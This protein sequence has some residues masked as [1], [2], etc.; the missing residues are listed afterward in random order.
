VAELPE[1]VTAL[2]LAGRGKLMKVFISWSGVRSKAVAQTLYTWLKDV[3]PSVDPWASWEDIS[4]GKQWT[5]ELARQ[6]EAI[7][8]GVVCLTPENLP[9]PWLLF[10]A[11][12]ISKL[13]MEKDAHLCT[14]LIE[15]S[16]ENLPEPL[17][18]FQSTRATKEDTLRMIQGINMAMK[19]GQGRLTSDRLNQAFE[20]YWPKLEH[21]LDTL[22]NPPEAVPTPKNTDGMLQEVLEIV[23]ALWKRQP[24]ALRLEPRNPQR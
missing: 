22:P 16:Y 4:K 17:M 1:G 19:H 7:H 12:A 18:A 9:E 15:V 5:I 23:R 11:G 8:V 21:C 13:Q 20:Q 3:M 6:L 10:E 24:D 2:W 14:Y